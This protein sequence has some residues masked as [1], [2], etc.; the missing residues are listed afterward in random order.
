MIKHRHFKRIEGKECD[1]WCECDECKCGDKI[2]WPRI[3]AKPVSA[4]SP[5]PSN[6]PTQY[7]VVPT[8][9]RYFYIPTENID[10]TSGATIP[11]N[12]FLDD[13]GNSVPEFTLFNPNGYTN[14][15]INAVMQEGGLYTVSTDSLTI[16]P[17]NGA[18]F[19]GTPIIIESLGFSSNVV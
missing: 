10:L 17:S 7:Y 14:L 15:Y 9:N 3:K 4:C 12:L 8:I 18:I 5:V 2:V 16:N 1:E 11:V 19:S 6:P 13:N